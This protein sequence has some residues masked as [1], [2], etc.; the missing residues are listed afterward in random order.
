MHRW[1][2]ELRIFIKWCLISL[3]FSGVIVVRFK[4]EGVLFNSVDKKVKNVVFHKIAFFFQNKFL[5]PENDFFHK[6][7]IMECANVYQ[8]AW[9]TDNMLWGISDK[10]EIKFEFLMNFRNSHFSFFIPWMPIG[11][12]QNSF[13]LEIVN[14]NFD[15]TSC[16]FYWNLSKHLENTGCQSCRVIA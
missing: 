4:P 7:D 8:S 2:L 11:P 1:T 5:A 3:K 12:G 9:Q 14:W 15:S 13:S 10:N 6:L 16:K